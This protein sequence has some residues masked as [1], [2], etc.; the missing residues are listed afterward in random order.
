MSQVFICDNFARVVYKVCGLA[1]APP[2]TN[3][4]LKQRTA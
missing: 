2:Q 4:V 3:L 1:I